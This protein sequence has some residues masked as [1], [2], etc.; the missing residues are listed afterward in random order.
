MSI[1]D[2]DDDY[3]DLVQSEETDNTTEN[4]PNGP[5]VNANG[6][7]VR[8]GD[9]CWKEIKIFS[10]AD[11]FKNSEICNILFKD[12]SRRKTRDFKYAEVEEYTCKH[13]RRTG[14]LPRPWT[15]RVIFLSDNSKVVVESVDGVNNHKHEEDPDFVEEASTNYRWT[16]DMEEVI[17]NGIMNHKK[18]N[19]I[20]RDLKD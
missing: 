8:G 17:K 5:R 15:V 12:F 7:K 6:V 4:V 10:T 20:K 9:K 11:E 14:F 1:Q 19:V 3:Q 16:N 2:S 13:S 18:P